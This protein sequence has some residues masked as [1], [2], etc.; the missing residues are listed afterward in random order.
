MKKRPKK[1]PVRYEN[2]IRYITQ[3][4]TTKEAEKAFESFLPWLTRQRQIARFGRFDEEL[5]KKWVREDID[6]VKDK[7]FDEDKLDALHDAYPNMPRRAP[8]KKVKKN[9]TRMVCQK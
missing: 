1:F 6:H 2:G 5:V 7:G 9:L 8:R 4:D 3:K